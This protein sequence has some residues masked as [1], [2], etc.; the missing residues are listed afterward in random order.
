[1]N[2]AVAIVSSIPKKRKIRKTTSF[3]IFEIYCEAKINAGKIIR[4]YLGK[5]EKLPENVGIRY[6]V[7]EY[8]A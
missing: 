5:E 6:A 1:M 2:I 8:I 3:F 7:K 4:T